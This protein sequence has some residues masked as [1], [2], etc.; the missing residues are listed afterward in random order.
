MAGNGE[1]KERRRLLARRPGDA[2]WTGRPFLTIDWNSTDMWDLGG[3]LSDIISDG[4]NEFRN[5]AR[6]THPAG[7]TDDEWDSV[8]GQMIDGFQANRE[9]RAGSVLDDESRRRL[10]RALD[11]FKRH[12]L[13]LG[14]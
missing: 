5:T 13:D 10:D 8:L 4:L 6:E 9:R 2:T 1:D 14:W 12:F 7:M 11:L 3:V